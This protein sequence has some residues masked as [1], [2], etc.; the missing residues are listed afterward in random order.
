[1]T[2]APNAELYGRG[3]DDDYCSAYPS[4]PHHYT[5]HSVNA[6]PVSYVDVCTSCK[7]VS[8]KA[9][10]PYLTDDALL[11]ELIKRFRASG[12]FAAAT[13]LVQLQRTKKEYDKG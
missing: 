6:R 11:E 8:S 5:S 10:W 9:L 2:G 4:E 3:S 12:A 13:R 7:H 1:M